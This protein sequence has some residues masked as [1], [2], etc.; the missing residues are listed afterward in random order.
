[1]SYLGNSPG[2]GSFIVSTERFNGNGACTQFTITQ[3]GISDA[4]AIEVLVSSVQQDPIN[5]YSITN[6]VITFTEAPPS[7]ANN[8]IVTYRATTV[9]TYSGITNAQISDGTITASKLASGVLPSAA[10]N[11]AGVYANAAFATANT[12]SASGSY[13]NSAFAAANTATASGSYA[14]SAFTVANNSLGIDTT[15]NTNI[16]SASSY[17][18]SGFSV[19]N[20]AAS[21][22]NSGFS[23]ANSAASYANSGFAKANSSVSLT[24]NV[25]G[26]LPVGNGGTGASTLTVNNVILGNTTSAVKFVAP[27]TTG[28]LLT[29]DGTTWTSAAASG[30]VTSVNSQT[31]AVVLTNAGEIGSVGVFQNS[32]SAD[33]AYSST[34]AGSSL[35][36]N[37]T[38]N[39]GSARAG[40]PFASLNSTTNSGYTGG[41][42]ALSGTWRKVSTGPIYDSQVLC[43]DTIRYFMRGLYI[44]VS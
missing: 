21:Y 42:T 32:G 30:G 41:G 22:A 12:G 14:N 5:S 4:N 10:A 9:I 20:S 34:I 37:D 43:G 25:S 29:S 26:T 8:I 19:A 7:G 27:G 17:A 18:N 36:Y 28:N 1:M 44:R 6:G 16:T 35:R 31:G 24:A 40:S 2:V 15:Q 38:T 13:A 33:L 11:S 3:T 23:V 39:S